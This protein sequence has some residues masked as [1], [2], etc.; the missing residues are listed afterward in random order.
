MASDLYAEL[1]GETGKQEAERPKWLLRSEA[2]RAAWSPR[3]RERNA[4][5]ARRLHFSLTFLEV[6]SGP[7]LLRYPIRFPSPPFTFWPEGKRYLPF[8]E[9]LL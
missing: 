5:Y 3:R 1:L 9:H 6:S 8:G 4:P 7:P 2:G